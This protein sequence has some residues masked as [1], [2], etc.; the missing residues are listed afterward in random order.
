[1]IDVLDFATENVLLNCSMVQRKC[2]FCMGKGMSEVKK[3]YIDVIILFIQLKV[4][5]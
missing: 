2:L 3:M 1:M 4:W 5:Y